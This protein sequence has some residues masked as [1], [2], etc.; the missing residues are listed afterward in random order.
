MSA[1]L[2][3]VTLAPAIARPPASDTRPAM[4][5]ICPICAEASVGNTRINETIAAGKGNACVA[6]T[7]TLRRCPL[8][9]DWRAGEMVAALAVNVPGLPIAREHYVGGR[10][11]AMVAAG[12]LPNP[13]QERF[14]DLATSL[15]QE[16]LTNLYADI[17]AER[18]LQ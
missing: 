5:P 2:V 10:Q 7:S 15:Q 12:A 3:A 18:V 17:L 8:S 13:L 9:G 11:M 1:A 6:G 4:M 16:R 14:D